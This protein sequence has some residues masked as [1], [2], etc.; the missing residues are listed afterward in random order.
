MINSLFYLLVTAYL[1]LPVQ[2]EATPPTP[3]V[4]DAA[5]AARER[6]SSSKLKHVLTD[7]DVARSGGPPALRPARLPK[8]RFE[9]NWK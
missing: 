5:K 6:K 3:S 9:R 1:A 7:D 2:Q 8:P 4:A